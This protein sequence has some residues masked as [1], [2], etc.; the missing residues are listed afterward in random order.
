MHR[1]LPSRAAAAADRAPARPASAPARRRAFPPPVP[2]AITDN[3]RAA[4]SP[5]NCPSC[6]TS[7]SVPS[8][9]LAPPARIQRLIDIGEIEDMRSMHD[10]CAELDRLDRILSAMRHQ[11]TAHEHDRRQPVEQSQFAH[12]VGDIDVGGRGRQFLA[13]A[14]R[15]LHAR[16]RRWCG[17]WPRRGGH[18][19]ARSRSAAAERNRA[20][21]LCTSTRISS[22]PGWVEAATITGRPRV[23]AIS[24]SSLAASAG[25]AWHVE[26]QIAGGDDV[27][28]AQRRKP[29]G[30]DAGLR[31]ADLELAEQRR[32]GRRAPA[33]SAETSAA[34]SGR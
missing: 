9:C 32:D 21:A 20:S 34:T 27:A 30:I 18:G 31:Q 17:R 22:S 23:S 29:F 11:R 10:R 16:H 8:A 6:L 2:P 12:G 14:Q 26:L 5:S 1:R 7:A 28:A 4:G 15:D 25:G 33:A 19:A 13:R 24:H 3:L